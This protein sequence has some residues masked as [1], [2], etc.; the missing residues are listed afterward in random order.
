MQFIAEVGW[1]MFLPFA[2]CF[3]LSDD[4]RAGWPISPCGY[5]NILEIVQFKVFIKGRESSFLRNDDDET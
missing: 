2:V 3:M 5:D 4:D 1:V